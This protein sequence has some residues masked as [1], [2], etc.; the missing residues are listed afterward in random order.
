[1]S[2]PDYMRRGEASITRVVTFRGGE[3]TGKR[4]NP[5]AMIMSSD[6]IGSR[7]KPKIVVRK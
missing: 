2:F 1:M 3:D 4:T 7:Y 5:S 6:R